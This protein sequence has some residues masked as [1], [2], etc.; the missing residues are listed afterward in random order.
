MRRALAILG[1][2]LV[3]ACGDHDGTADAGAATD[4]GRDA[5]PRDGGPPDAGPMCAPSCE[6]E[7]ACCRGEESAECV[8]LGTDVRHCGAC[9]LDCVLSG[10][11]DSCQGAQCACGEFGLGCIGS[12]GSTCC[13]PEDGSGAATC[14]DL[15]RSREHCGGCNRACVPEQANRCDGA[16]CVCGGERR[17]CAGTE[18]EQCC[19]DR[20]E[21]YGCV[22]VTVDRDHCGACG[23]RCGA[24]LR[25]E[26]GACVPL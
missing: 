5:G 7:Q 14:A 18:T 2:A 13:V 8:E 10:R 12:I 6:P 4:A 3:L 20:F 26:A 24:G 23:N 1:L 21:V 19:G 16:R 22:D 15:A 9:G 17:A 11:G 25:C